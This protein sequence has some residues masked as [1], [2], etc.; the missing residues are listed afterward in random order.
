[1][2]VE[3]DGLTA[4]RDNVAALVSSS[5]RRRKAVCA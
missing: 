5:G 4:A 1:M 2:P 3:A